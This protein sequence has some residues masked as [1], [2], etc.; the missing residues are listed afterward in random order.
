[1]KRVLIITYYWPPSSSAG[2][3][4]WLK[5][6]KYLPEYGWEP[7]IYTPL[8]PNAFAK[9]KSLEK[10]IS[11]NLSVIKR[12]IWEPYS[13]YKKLLGNNKSSKTISV[14]PINNAEE[15]TFIKSFSLWV[16]ANLF[17]PDPRVF[18][19]WPS[20]KFLKKYLSAHPVD[21][22]VSTGPPHSMH[23]IAQKVS[24]AT[25][26]KW[27]ADFRDPWTKIYY[28]KHLPL[29]RAASWLHAKL[30]LSVIKDADTVIAISNGDKI[31]YEDK[32]IANGGNTPVFNIP[33]GFDPDDFLYEEKTPES[34]FC[35]TYTGSFSYECNLSSLWIVLAEISKNNADFKKDLKI[36]LLGKIDSQIILS[37]KNQGLGENLNVFG[38]VPHSETTVLQQQACLLLLPL[39]KEPEAQSIIPGKFFEYLASGK[40]VLAFGPANGDLAKILKETSSG[41]IFAW[42]DKTNLKTAIL[43]HYNIYLASKQDKNTNPISKKTN[44][45][46]KY[47]RKELTAKLSEIL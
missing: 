10:D 2:V 12:P 15:K 30:E 18:W 19:I 1:M 24:R 20:V 9:D 26:I 42:D 29:C 33:N 8:N 44:L 39:R 25:G 28:F 6:S 32:I 35:L 40:H 36:M 45:I 47:S 5:F 21:T 17:I 3:Q 38:H 23:L 27:I 34:S 4:R 41:E 22:I 43:N 13:F 11:Q 37:I 14:N 7:I 31:N 46:Y 16:R